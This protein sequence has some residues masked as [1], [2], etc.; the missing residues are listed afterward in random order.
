MGVPVAGKSTISAA[1]WAQSAIG[2]AVERGRRDRSPFEWRW[3]R[4]FCRPFGGM[5]RG[6][7]V[8]PG[9]EGASSPGRPGDLARAVRRGG[10]RDR[11]SGRGRLQ[12]SHAKAVRVRSR[13]LDLLAEPA[14]VARLPLRAGD[15]RHRD[16]PRS[17][18]A[19]CLAIVAGRAS[20]RDRSSAAVPRWVGLPPRSCMS[21]STC[22]AV[23][24]FRIR[25]SDRRGSAGV[26]R[27]RRI[28]LPPLPVR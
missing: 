18:R 8:C 24:A 6:S 27:R 4:I 15:P 17:R 14:S 12:E 2:G 3:R 16:P 23:G 26:G 28:L 19:D 25:R 7:P 22:V 13:R 5:P 9:C 11:G 1:A 20:R 10:R 21:R